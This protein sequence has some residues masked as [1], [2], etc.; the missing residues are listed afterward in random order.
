MSKLKEIEL[1]V[2]LSHISPL[3]DGMVSSPEGTFLSPSPPTLT[4]SDILEDSV[5]PM[6]VRDQGE[7]EDKGNEEKKKF[8][9]KLIDWLKC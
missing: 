7:M 6:I 4:H 5:R 3:S 2:D 8:K 1:V 9:Q